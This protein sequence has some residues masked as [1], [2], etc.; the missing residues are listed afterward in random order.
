MTATFGLFCN[1]ESRRAE[2]FSIAS[3]RLLKERPRFVPWQ[4]VVEGR[5]WEQQFTG[6]PQFLRLESPGRN[7]LVEKAMLLKGY[8]QADEESSRRW[9]Q[10][11]PDTLAVLPNDPGRVLP[12]R[13]WYLGWR[14]VLKQ[15]DAWARQRGWATR[16]LCPPED[17]AC[18]FDKQACQQKLETHDIAVPPSLGLPRHF[19]ELW[20]AMRLAGRR[21][22]FLKP[23]HGSSASGVVALES[24]HTDVQAFSTLDV[25][26]AT[27]GLRLYNQ[28]RIRTWRGA[29]EV[30][31]LVDAVCGE[32]C[33]AQVWIPKAGIHGRPFDLRVVVIGGKARHVMLRLGRGPMTNSQL[34][35]GKG[36]VA[37]LRRKMGEESWLQLLSHCEAAMARCFPRSLYAGLDVLVEPDFRTTRILEIN[38]FGDLLP[39]MLHE[40]RDTYEWEI[41]EA[42]RRVP[43]PAVDETG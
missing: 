7:W 30:R 42:L 43:S 4:W 14:Q 8:S 9:R 25:A 13:Q 16:W 35:G 22:V 31:R 17:V 24:S 15:L 12:M 5:P 21:R 3:G 6:A 37:E 27:D 2:G 36:D 20:E 38:A 28:R 39:R 33:L 41:L 40:G 11:D 10:L 1:P 23:C 29:S 18:L 26:E 32:R 19:D 34:L